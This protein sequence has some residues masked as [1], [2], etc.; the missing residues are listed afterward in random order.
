MRSGRPAEGLEHIDR[1]D[2]SFEAKRR[3]KTIVLTLAGE[4]TVVEACR[5]LGVGSSRFHVVR[6][7]ALQAAVERL[8]PHAAGRPPREERVSTEH[9]RR[10]ESRLEQSEADLRRER[11]RT[12]I[13][14]VTAHE[15]RRWHRRDPRESG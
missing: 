3:M 15:S 5:R 7:E 10:L 1:L 2:G 14:L 6:R 13:A 11:A 4:M 12:E 9:V 8:E